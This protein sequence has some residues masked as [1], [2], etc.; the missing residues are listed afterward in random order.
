MVALATA[1]RQVTV[2]VSIWKPQ[3]PSRQ[4]S[5]GACTFPG[6]VLPPS[7][8]LSVSSPKQV[9]LLRTDEKALCRVVWSKAEEL[10]QAFDWLMKAEKSAECT[11]Y[12]RSGQQ[13]LFPGSVGLASPK[14]GRHE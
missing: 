13:R 2:S 1:G 3:P 9:L 7:S 4:V 6:D 11:L 14:D 10:G 5:S 8:I 12:R